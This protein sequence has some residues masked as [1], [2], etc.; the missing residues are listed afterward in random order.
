MKSVLVVS[1]FSA[2]ILYVV[3]P[4]S[5]AEQGFQDGDFFSGL[6]TDFTSGWFLEI[7]SLI[8][9]TTFISIFFP[10]IEFGVFWLATRH[11]KR[12]MDQKSC[13]PCNKKN[14]NAKSIQ[15][16]EV[17]YSGPA[18]FV[19]YR[20][21]GIV[22][23]VWVTFFFGPGM[24]LLFPIAAFGMTFYYVTERLRMAYSYARPPMYDSRLS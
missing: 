1:F 15:E 6:Y 14:T 21:A 22:N 10:I 12:C 11:L 24:P 2:G 18:F 16:F 17:I 7:G 3:A 8:A 23:L 9:Q 5:F 19:H 4:W 20:L 13:C